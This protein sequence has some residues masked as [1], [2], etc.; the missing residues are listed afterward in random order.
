VRFIAVSDGIDT[1]RQDNDIAPFK[2]IL[3]EMYAK[4]ISKKI[5]AAF[6]VK[7]MRGD[8]QGAFAPFG[9]KKHPEIVGKLVIDEVSSQTIKLIFDLAKQ[10][11]GASRIKTMLYE[12]K[13]LTP[14]GYLHSINPKYFA[15][16]FENAAEYE[17]YAWSIGTVKRLLDNDIYLGHTTHYKEIS[18]SF[19]SK[20]RQ[21]QPPDKWLKV[22]NTHEPLIDQETW[23]FVHDKLEHRGRTARKYPPSLFAKIVRCADC[24][25]AMWLTSPQWDFPTQKMSQR[26]YFQCTTHRDTGKYKCGMHN[27][28]YHAV[29]TIVLADL[30]AFAKEAA[31][32]EQELLERLSSA[33]DTRQRQLLKQAERELQAADK[34]L[35][36]LDS[37]LTRL[38]EDNVAG[39]MNNANYERMFSKYQLEQ[40]TLAERHKELQRQVNAVRE[41]AG[42]AERWMELI[43]RHTDLQELTAPVIN[44]LIEKILIHQAEKVDGKRRQKIEIFYRFIGNVQ[45]ET[46]TCINGRYVI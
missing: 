16:Q 39:R 46:D 12:R 31:E 44:E 24:G 38:F 6:R 27:A 2:N 13:I 19:K 40:G 20:K 41:T 17:P 32:N 15:K 1:I 14:A 22:E 43:K 28:N 25:R 36:E 5:K 18:V 7:L 29:C 26:R 45:G 10:G 34:R 33:N 8:H 3:N 35:R 30:Q 42:N 21:L 11:Y 9:Y 4:D 37:L 23:D